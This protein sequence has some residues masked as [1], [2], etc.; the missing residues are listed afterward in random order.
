MPIA[1]LD[2]LPFPDRS[3]ISC[4][5]YNRYIT[6]AMVKY[7]ISQQ[8]TRGCPFHCLYCHRIWPKKHAV[9]S[10]E[11]IFAEVKRYYDIGI[12]RFSFVDD[13]FNLDRKN[14]M[15]FF[16]LVIENGLDIHIFFANGLRGDL[17]TTDY[18]DLMVEA[19]TVNAAVAL[20]TASPRLQKLI[21]KN[22]N[23]EK[24]RRNVE[25]ICRKYPHV[26]INLFTMIGFPTET[27]EEAMMNLDFIKS[28]RWVHF[29]TPAI[30]IIFPNTEMEQLAIENGI[31][32]EAIA[33]SENLA[34]HDLPQSLP[35][36]KS[37]AFDF[38]TR[39]LHEYFLL[40]ER[41]VQVLP[42]QMKVL[43]GDEL[44]QKYN[45]YISE[46]ASSFKELLRILG[47]AGEELEP[48]RFIEEDWVRVPDLDKRLR[49][50]HPPH[51][52]GEK[53]V[54]ILLL[55]LSQS[56]S[57]EGHQLNDLVEP[58]LGLMY[59]LT[60]L[61]RQFG[62]KIEGKIA[63][64]LVDFNSYGELKD[65]LE[66]FKPDIIGIRTLTFYKDFFHKTAAMIREWGINVPI[67]SGGPYA[68]SSYTTVLEDP[69]I[70]LVV[71]G[72]GEITLSA[73]VDTF[74]ENKGKFP[75]KDVLKEIPGIAFVP[76]EN[77]STSGPGQR[78]HTL[79]VY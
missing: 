49:E 24:L 20:E 70:N 56:F 34:F 13:I 50:I 64:S 4:E 72:E 10:A 35:F 76:A 43:T 78:K 14:S 6:D 39:Y 58:P 67:I 42:H 75:G 66:I 55:D 74:I 22:V 48:R 36:D 73:L 68:T 23:I 60:Y 32:R 41:L 40:K 77:D 3:L 63:K 44:V 47:I 31:S 59:L 79:P 8:A 57:T 54:K 7:C 38:K 15:K 33:R 25:Y 9:R 30:L 61:N 37:I 5:K 45:S 19:G 27:P 28:I 46:H 17:L 52:P 21:K 65:M 51:I 2:E 18:I 26:I 62:S 16:R 69:N 11:N 29:V 12:R 53:A 71:L 1:N